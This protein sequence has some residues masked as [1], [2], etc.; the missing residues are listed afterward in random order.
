MP[1]I[2]TSESVVGTF[3]VL[4]SLEYSNDRASIGPDPLVPRVGLSLMAR[5][6]IGDLSVLVGTV[7][8]A[9]LGALFAIL[10]L[11]GVLE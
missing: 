1:S 4:P 7:V 8:G 11:C 3:T 5:L 9:V 10:D 2:F 6:A